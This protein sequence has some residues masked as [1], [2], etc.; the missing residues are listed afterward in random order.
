MATACTPLSHIAPPDP[1]SALQ[2]LKV[3]PDTDTLLAPAAYTPPPSSPADTHPA[4]WLRLRLRLPRPTQMQPPPC[5]AE[6]PRISHPT[7]LHVLSLQYMV[8]PCCCASL[9]DR[10][11]FTT[12]TPLRS[13]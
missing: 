2:P 12:A 5:A 1:F 9:Y 10:V 11:V 8:P 13:A 4:S 6:S 3:H 7:K